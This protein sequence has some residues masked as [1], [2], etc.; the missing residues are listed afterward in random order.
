MPTIK[1][2]NIKGLNAIFFPDIVVP[3]ALPWLE[4][5]FNGSDSTENEMFGHSV[6]MSGDGLW[7]IVGS[8][9]GGAQTTGGYTDNEPF[10]GEAYVFNWDGSNWVESAKLPD[11][12]DLQDE[13]FFGW[14]VAIN[15][16]GTKAFVSSR[17]APNFSSA[18]NVGEVYEYTRSG[19]VWSYARK[20]TLTAGITDAFFGYSIDT[21]SLGATIAIGAPGRD[22]NPGTGLEENYGFAF[23]TEWTG[24]FWQDIRLVQSL[25]A[26]DYRFGASVSIDN[27]ASRIAVGA[28]G[29]DSSFLGP[30]FTGYTFV[31]RNDGGGTWTEEQILSPSDGIGRDYFGGHV[32][33][34]GD[35]N[36]VVASSI[37]HSTTNS[38][39]GAV[40]VFSRSGTTWT[41]EAKIIP[42]TSTTDYERFGFSV[43]INENGTRIAVGV[44]LGGRFTTLPGTQPVFLYE[45][46]GSSWSSF[47]ELI[48]GE[49]D[50]YEGYG[51]A[52]SMNNTGNR[53]LIGSSGGPDNEGTATPAGEVHV[54]HEP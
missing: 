41:E 46:I 44:D 26:E 7:C 43:A 2:K 47:H 10:R 33:I 50:V 28:P 54:F 16:D 18:P 23:A 12:P 15:Q 29:F 3:P 13:D 9:G 31:F 38:Q 21:D 37:N 42:S 5:V 35:G 1:G 34:S 8:P 4:F 22:F 49:P 24:T 6:A 52:V 20:V 27:T 40:Y 14:A 19:S 51:N 11:N 48:S 30:N 45:R 32:A 39:D 36:Y 17:D 53:V 25:G